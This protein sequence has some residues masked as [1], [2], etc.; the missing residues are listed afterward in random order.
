VSDPAP[1]LIFAC[2]NPGRGD[3]GLGPAFLD[4]IEAAGI[5]GVEC[6]V[7]MQLQVEHITDLCG[8]SM[9]L[10]VDADVSCAPPFVHAPL[11]AE[12]DDSYSS[13]AMSPAALLHAYRKVYANEPPPAFVLRIRGYRFALG[14]SLSAEARTN[15]AETVAY[16]REWCAGRDIAAWNRIACPL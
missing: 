15:L 13:H 7:D 6:L 10:F 8:R 16:A 2:G 11:K 1:I 4:R 14:D 5:P 12:A 3:D 9:V